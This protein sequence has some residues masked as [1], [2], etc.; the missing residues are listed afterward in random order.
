MEGDALN[1]RFA[2]DNALSKFTGTIQKKMKLFQTTP[3][4]LDAID[5]YPSAQPKLS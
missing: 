2:S 3:N 4:A 1:A 5:V